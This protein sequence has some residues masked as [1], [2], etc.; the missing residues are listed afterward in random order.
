M[1]KRERVERTY[2]LGVPDRPPFVPAIYEHK[3]ALIGRT[4]S[5]V[6]RDGG[7]LHEALLRE[8][9]TY[10][11]DMLVVGVDVYNVEAETLGCRVRYFDDS[12]DVPS[13]AGPLLRSPGDLRKLRVPDPEAEGRMPLFLRAARRLQKEFGDAMI[14]RGA[15]TGPF[16]LASALTGTEDLL[17][18]TADDPLVVRRLLDF[19]GTVT[20]AYGRAFLAC[21]A[22]IIL[23]DSKA[24]P[25]AASPQIFHEFV[26][27]VYRDLV[28]PV[29]TAS[30]AKDV[31]LIIGGDT[32][33]ILEDL[34]RTG[35]TQFLC[36]AGS[37]LE[38]FKTRCL[39]ERRSF[40]ASVDARLVHRGTP[41]EI[42]AE[43][44]RILGV[45]KNQPGLLF[46]CGVVAYDTDPA[47]V[48]AL[49]SALMEFSA[50]KGT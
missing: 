41:A 4:P 43:A 48:L 2:A 42:R 21:G 49:R 19:C 44:L 28:V 35:A 1:T 25:G 24:S 11:P 9:E 17:L 16:S 47:N 32:T 18:A 27:P 45:T 33:P 20:A 7:L 40:R 10:D 38:A 29:L 13:V 39:E 50:G 23:F 37:D 14:I 31:P 12:N 34:L 15:L 26:L 3:A 30:G 8:L 5:Q 22:G 6:C 36:D 46:G